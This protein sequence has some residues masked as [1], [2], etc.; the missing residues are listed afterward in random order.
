MS[1]APTARLLQL[2]RRLARRRH[3]IVVDR[4]VQHR[5]RS[6]MKRGRAFR[7]AGDWPSDRCT[8]ASRA[9]H[10]QQRREHRGLQPSSHLR[11]FGLARRDKLC[12][13]ANPKLSHAFPAAVELSV[14]VDLVELVA[15]RCAADES[16]ISGRLMQ[17]G[18]SDG[19]LLA[20]FHSRSSDFMHSIGTDGWSAS[21]SAGDGGAVDGVL[22]EPPLLVAIPAWWRVCVYDDK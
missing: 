3:T 8:H 14:A 11:P 15:R 22:A 6:R 2:P 20:H 10:W 17:R 16:A 4:F 13:Q 21:L 5:L 9:V 7:S 19:F 1:G 12:V 18:R